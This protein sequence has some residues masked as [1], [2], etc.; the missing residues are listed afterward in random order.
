MNILSLDEL[1]Q[2][3][4][5]QWGI[6]EHPD[7]YSISTTANESDIT[8]MIDLEGVSFGELVSKTNSLGTGSLGIKDEKYPGIDPETLGLMQQA[9]RAKGMEIVQRQQQRKQ[10]QGGY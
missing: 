4:L 2:N 3:L 7:R 9:A 1:K 8:P 6:N 10:N 5:K